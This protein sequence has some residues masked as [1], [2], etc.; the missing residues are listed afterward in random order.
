MDVNKYTADKLKKLRIENNLTQEKLAEE[1]NITQQQ[2]ARYENNLRQFKQ[3]F[4]YQLAE[5]FGVSINYF[6]P[7]N[8][9]T[10]E[11]KENKDNLQLMQQINSL[12]DDKKEMVKEFINLLNKK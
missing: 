12:P 2:I 8:K 10:L 1:L 11:T 5:Y 9:N 3:D 7:Q 4:I 6:F